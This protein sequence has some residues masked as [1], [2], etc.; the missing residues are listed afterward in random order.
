MGGRMFGSHI[1]LEPPRHIRRKIL[2]RK[3]A[4]KTLCG[5]PESLT[6]L[7][8]QLGAQLENLI[9]ELK[10]I[11]KATEAIQRADPGFPA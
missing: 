6:D 2:A 5:A 3:I 11:R 7:G 1:H 8:S 10:A 4:P 9:E